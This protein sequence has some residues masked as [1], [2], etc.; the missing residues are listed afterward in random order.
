MKTTPCRSEEIKDVL[1]A[2]RQ[3]AEGQQY[4]SRSRCADW[5]LDVLNAAEDPSVR[6]EVKEVLANFSHGNI[7]SAEE[8]LAGIDRIA[9][10]ATLAEV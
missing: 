5:L 10:A 1:A 4:L 6:N 9:M 2:A 7:A 8:F 3:A